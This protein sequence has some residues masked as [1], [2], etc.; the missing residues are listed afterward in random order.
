MQSRNEHVFRESVSEAVEVEPATN[1][2]S[3]PL[4]VLIVEDNPINQRVVIGVLKKGGYC[5]TVTVAANGKE[6]VAAFAEQ[7]DEPFDLVLM[8]LQMPIMNGF[9]A[10]ALIRAQEKASGRRV[11]IIALTANTAHGYKETRQAEM[12]DYLSKPFEIADLL[13]TIERAL[14]LRSRPS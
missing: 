4:R 8:D 14:T 13:L 12:D 1:G 3:P 10:T 2:T 5:L 7:G 9:E 6:A 11:P